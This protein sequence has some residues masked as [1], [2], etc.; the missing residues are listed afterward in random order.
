MNKTKYTEQQIV[1]A[2][3]QAKTGAHE[4]PVSARIAVFATLQSING[5]YWDLIFTDELYQFHLQ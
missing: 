3:K 1:F 2:L 5:N 4:Q